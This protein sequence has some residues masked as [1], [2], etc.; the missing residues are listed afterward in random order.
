[1]KWPRKSVT[2][3]AGKTLMIQDDAERGTVEG[4]HG[5][6]RQRTHIIGTIG[7]PPSNVTAAK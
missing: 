2:S 5:A 3:T 1:M 6:T 4:I 7:A